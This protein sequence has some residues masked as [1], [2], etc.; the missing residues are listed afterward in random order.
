MNMKIEIIKGLLFAM[1]I[2]LLLINIYLEDQ[3]LLKK[4]KNLILLL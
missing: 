2:T 4:K 1:A 3:N